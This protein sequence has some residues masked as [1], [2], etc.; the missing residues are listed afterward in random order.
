MVSMSAWVRLS[1]YENLLAA[2]GIVLLVAGGRGVDTLLL[3]MVAAASAVTVGPAD[4][5]FLEKSTSSC[6]SFRTADW[7]AEPPASTGLKK[8]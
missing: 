3:S 1:T 6:N 4:A 2:A 7:L 5:G 8:R